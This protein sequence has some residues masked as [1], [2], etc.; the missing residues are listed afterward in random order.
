MKHYHSI[1]GSGLVEKGRDAYVFVK[2][3]GSNLRFEWTKKNGWHR[4]GTRNQPLDRSN[5]Y[6]GSAIDLFLNKYGDELV[7]IFTTE[8]L[9]RSINQF[10]VFCEWFG[11]QSFA[12]FHAQ[13]DEKTLVLFDVNPHKKGILGPKQFLD[14]FGGLPDA[15]EM[16]G[17][18]EF[19][20]AFI[21]SVRD[22]S[23]PCGSKLAI[24]NNT[25]EGVVCKGGQGH[26]LWMAKVK[27]LAYLTKLK[28]KYK[29]NWTKYWE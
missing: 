15:A 10:M 3:D 27:T 11:C 5:P 18:V 7:R 2:Y 17:V 16:L 22:G 19:D 23:F 21:Q 14:I 8:K 1:P 13:D 24:A 20:E 25:P 4:F 6:F 29:Q 26:Q 9:L 12:D 28:E